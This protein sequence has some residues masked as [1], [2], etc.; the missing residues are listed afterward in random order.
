MCSNVRCEVN[1]AR[2]TL[3]PLQGKI[4]RANDRTVDYDVHFTNRVAAALCHRK[5]SINI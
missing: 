1:Y 4:G 2:C 3:H 5:P